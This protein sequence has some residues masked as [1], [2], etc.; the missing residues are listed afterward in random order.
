MPH[1]LE[2]L[3]VAI[4]LLAGAVAVAAARLRERRAC[5]QVHRAD[6]ASLYLRTRRA[7][8]RP[9]P[10]RPD[11]RRELAAV[12]RAHLIS[13]PTDELVRLGDAA[14]LGAHPFAETVFDVV[15]GLLDER[16][17]SAADRLARRSAWPALRAAETREEPLAAS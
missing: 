5:D 15:Y 7:L 2:I 17:A 16:R 12:L 4:A 10:P 1:R 11:P 8:R 13:F 3:L 9:S 14:L 6:I